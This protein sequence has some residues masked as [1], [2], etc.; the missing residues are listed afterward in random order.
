MLPRRTHFLGTWPFAADG[1][2]GGGL[3]IANCNKWLEIAVILK[4]VHALVVFDVCRIGDEHGTTTER[5]VAPQDFADLD[6]NSDRDLLSRGS[7]ERSSG[8]SVKC[9]K[10]KDAADKENIE[11][12]KSV[13]KHDKKILHRL[14]KIER[15]EE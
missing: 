4:V 7:K 9:F 8:R 14:E 6:A 3:S 1:G 10:E 13:E 5:P 15:I 12:K 2:L 11:N